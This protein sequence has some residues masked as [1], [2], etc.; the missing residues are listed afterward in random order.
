[1]KD[2]SELNDIG[3]FRFALIAPALNH[4]HGYNSNATYFKDIA[5]KTHMFNGKEQKV[6]YDCLRKWLQ[7]Y[8]KNGIN[9]LNGHH[10]KDK[11]SSRKLS[12]ETILRI[13]E[14]REQ[15]PKISGT[16][17]YNKLVDEGFFSTSDISKSTVL[18]FIKHN[19]LKANQ[20]A[21]IERRMFEMDSINQCWQSDT[22]DGPYI[23]INDQKVRTKLIMFID[24]KSRMITGFDFFLNDNAINMQKVFKNAILTYGIPK[25][26][27]VDN[28]GP[29]NNKQLKL[30]C[31]TLGIQ[32]IHAKPYSPESKA[33]IERCFKTIKEGWMNCT[34]WNA[35]KS[36]KDI[37]YSLAQFIQNYNNKFH[38]STQKTPNERWHEEFN[39]VKFC[40]EST[41]KEAFLHRIYRKVRKDR[42][43]KF[44][45]KYYEVP[46][47]FVDQTVELR[48]DPTNV[49]DLFIYE[50]DKLIC[51]CNEVNVTA[52]SKIKR[53]NNIDYSKVLNDERDV[54]EMDGD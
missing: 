6:T 2:S 33:K 13:I 34:D 28:G 26:L 3:L 52:N 47:K 35:F 39:K 51:V 29:Y 31:A 50:N 38:T 9:A 49:E 19:N 46:F 15:F 1:V 30:I 22:S 44:D 4:T 27:F 12:N 43:V 37:K 18:R 20:I 16:S 21:K 53:K 45:K 36:L 17:I 10:R 41:I 32:L 24:D 5:N 11:N 54:L 8:K 14:M 42:T 23:L 7:L 48:Y 25:Q 40:D